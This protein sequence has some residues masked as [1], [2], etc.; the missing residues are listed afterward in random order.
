MGAPSKPEN[1]E[2]P[3]VD[4][5]GGDEK[6]KGQVIDRGAYWHVI[7]K[8]KINRDKTID[9]VIKELFKDAV[10]FLTCQ[11]SLRMLSD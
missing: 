4:K 2:R 10:P 6:D 3:T 11:Q 7:D 5:G 9:I 8:D 1:K